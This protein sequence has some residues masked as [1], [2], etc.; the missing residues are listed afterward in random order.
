MG[1]KTS[2]LKN[3]DDLIKDTGWNNEKDISRR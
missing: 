1:Y 3:L 2:I